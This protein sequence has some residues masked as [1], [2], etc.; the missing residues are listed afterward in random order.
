MSLDVYLRGPAEQVACTCSHCWDDHMREDREEFFQANITHNLNKMAREAGI[1]EAC[2]RPEE[3]G[4]T[5][6][7][8]LIE[9]LEHGIERLKAEPERFKQFNPSNGWGDY[10]GFIQ[11]LEN[12]LAACIEHPNA[13]ITVSR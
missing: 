6:A 13:E 4:I 11:W 3:I 8:Q 1:Y 7:E 2:W 12:Y 5:K 10:D 9:P